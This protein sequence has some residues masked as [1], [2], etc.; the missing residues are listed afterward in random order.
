MSVSIP[1]SMEIELFYDQV[2]NLARA[3][4]DSKEYKEMKQEIGRIIKEYE[5]IKQ[6]HG[7]FVDEKENI[8]RITLYLRGR[9]NELK[10]KLHSEI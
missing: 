8:E 10:E 4:K 3:I 1:N 5:H 2:N 7:F 9:I 6:I